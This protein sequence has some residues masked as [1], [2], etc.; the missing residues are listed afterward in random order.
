[1]KLRKSQQEA[2]SRRAFAGGH[3]DVI[4]PVELEAF[5]RKAGEIVALANEHQR[6][7]D[8][9]EASRFNVFNFIDPDENKRSE[10]LKDLLDPNGAHGQG[11]LFLSLLLERLGFDASAMGAEAAT[12][13]C[14]APT[15]GIE[16]YRRRID[17]F[18]ECGVLIAIEN[19]IDAIEQADQVPAYLKHLEYC[20]RGNAKPYRLIYLTPNGRVPESIGAVVRK[21][22]LEAGIL[23]CW[24]Y[25][26]ELRAWLETCRDRC[27]ARKIQDFLTDFI[28]YNETTM[29]HYAEADEDQEHR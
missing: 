12:V 9:T 17:V 28:S 1:M 24:S 23:H 29:Q 18:V 25:R 8:R 21:N 27:G 6:R 14:E 10:V 16:Q 11:D 7:R 3:D 20:S 15:H 22:E 2:D 4:G 26:R 13:R 19:K 5:F